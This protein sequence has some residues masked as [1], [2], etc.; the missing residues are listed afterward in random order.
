MAPNTTKNGEVS[1]SIKPLENI[2]GLVE[3]VTYHNLENGF[4]V[5]RLQVYKSRLNLTDTINYTI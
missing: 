2:S 5:L 4:C 1:K 3:R